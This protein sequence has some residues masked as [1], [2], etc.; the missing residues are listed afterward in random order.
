MEQKYHIDISL[1]TLARVVFF[2]ILLW[3]IYFLRDLILI[4][5]TAI[6]ISSSV[7]PLKKMM[8]LYKIPKILSVVVIY[9][10]IF[11]FFTTL[12]YEMVP[13]FLEQSR[14]FLD[15]LPQV[16]T[17]I[18][19]TLGIAVVGDLLSNSFSFFDD[20]DYQSVIGSVATSGFTALSTF[21]NGI[22]S[23]I[24]IILFSVYFSLEDR[25]IHKFVEVL[26]PKQYEKYAV[27]LVT[28]SQRKIGLWFRGQLLL[29]AITAVLVY[30]MLTLVGVPNAFFL[31]VLAGV[32]ELVPILG[33]VIAII[34][35]ILLAFVSGGFT[36]VL[37]VIAI[38]L[39]IQQFQSNLI[40]PL[41]VRKVVGVPIPLVI[42]SLVAGAQLFGFIGVVIAIPVVAI[43]QEVFNDIGSGKIKKIK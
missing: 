20:I 34:P 17:K 25:S 2:G 36:L 16:S 18:K 32:F 1:A 24:L 15:N 38:Y 5:I 39:I 27:D 8:V 4:I 6:I 19:E 42:I 30:L 35:A 23:F 40:Y 22:V 12:F 3:L 43:L 14:I 11:L 10:F 21:A 33:S 28:R 13:I 29:G 41:V 26:T 31:A 7:E 9:L 37:I